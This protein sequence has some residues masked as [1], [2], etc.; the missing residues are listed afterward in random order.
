M[1]S[2]T[3]AIKRGKTKMIKRYLVSLS[4]GHE[5]KSNECWDG[6]P[7][8]GIV[9]EPNFVRP[10]LLPEE[11]KKRKKALKIECSKREVQTYLP[12]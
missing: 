4:D 6:P 7:K 3:E 11:T 2:L 8:E 5:S 10:Y 12:T 9:T 1:A